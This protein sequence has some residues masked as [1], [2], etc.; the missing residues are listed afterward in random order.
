MHRFQIVALL[1]AILSIGKV[2]A[3]HNRAGEIT[4]RHL[5]GFQYEATIITYTKADSPADRNALGISWGDGFIDTIPRINGGGNGEIVAT[6]IKKNIYIGVHTYPAPSIYTL[7]FEDANRNGGVVN[8]PNSIN[9]PFFVS[10][11]LIINPFL[12]INNSVLLLNPPIDQACPG[13]IFI[14]N[15]GAFDPD[16][17]SISYRLTQCKGEGGLT[18]PGFTQPVAS[19]SFSLNPI[20]GDLIWDTPLS[21]SIGEYNVAFIVEEWRKGILIGFV[22][23]D[24]QITVAPCSNQPPIFFELPDLC[25]D[26]G[27]VV[28]FEVA[29]NDPDTPLQQITLSATG[30]AFQFDAPYNAEF[31]PI[32]GNGTAS[33]T[34]TWN[35]DCAHVKKEPHLFSFRTV[36]N[37]NPNLSDYET[38]QIKVVAQ[39]PSPLI[40]IPQNNGILLNWSLSPCPQAL[41]YA[42]YR[43][44][45]FYGFVPNSCETG[46]PA[47]TGYLLLDT[48]LGINTLSYLD[49]NQGQGLIQG[50]SYCYLVTALFG[51]GAESYATNEVCSELNKT[52][53]IIT[54]VS[55]RQTALTNGSVFL[56]WSK[57]SIVDT[58]LS[59]NSYRYVVER[60]VNNL[61]LAIDSLENLN[62]TTFIDSSSSVNT[63][64]EA[65][66]YKIKLKAKEN[67]DYLYIGKSEIATS[68][69][70]T[71]FGKP[72][73]VELQWNYTVPWQNDSFIVYRRLNGTNSFDSI[74]VTTL[75]SFTDVGLANGLNICYKIK[76][77]G[78]Y[79][80]TGTIK[81]IE[82]YS[83]ES[84]AI[85]VD[86]IPPCMP[87]AKIDSNCDSLFNILTWK[88][89]SDS[90]L[91]EV[92]KIKIYYAAL[93]NEKPELIDSLSGNSIAEYLHIPAFGVAG[94]YAIIAIDSFLN[95]S[96]FDTICVDNCPLYQLP[97]VFSPNGDGLN[98]FFK[99]FPFKFIE[100]VDF[101]V[102][103]RWGKMVFQTKDKDINWTGKDSFSGESLTD[104]VYFCVCT[105]NEQRLKGIV[106]RVIKGT[107]TIIDKKSSQN[108][109]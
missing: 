69:F 41:G 20:T 29:A 102:Y 11:E 6:D 78:A 101:I 27:T 47:Y 9:I 21:G 72:N 62:D 67:L 76:S 23:R 83:Q 16:G 106:S 51:D 33:Q 79:S 70:L 66:N 105:V 58:S 17:D 82:N 96:V 8:I 60:K 63:F 98:D 54:N 44:N 7:S 3:T 75:N 50:N 89:P 57:P 2:H 15:P 55:I 42:I 56:A 108:Q 5:G 25:V 81:P 49:N 104:G 45:G 94:C 40:T 43:K 65:K 92:S 32:T 68:I 71:T 28:Q 14:H 99:P 26:A 13:Q 48:I 22:V 91:K 97:N 36:D 80:G 74:G 30:G 34:F 64:N 109:N 73:S 87:N 84:C 1:I 31:T 77:M 35:T 24:M 59:L 107:I 46:V 88:F 10:T 86:L 52:L 19:N 100:S 90:C 93:F 61:F 37:G 85:P 4:Y 38:V 39:A 53:P 103:N 12:G 95:E 18:I